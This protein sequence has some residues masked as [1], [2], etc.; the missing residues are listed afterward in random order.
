MIILDSEGEDFIKETHFDV[1]VPIHV[2]VF[3]G[4]TKIFAYPFAVDTDTSPFTVI[5]ILIILPDRR[6]S[7][8]DT[9]S[10]S[11]SYICLSLTTLFHIRN[12]DVALGVLKVVV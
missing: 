1:A 5:V 2:E 6:T 11:F 12:G 9:P 4:E 3:E 10:F 7:T 8:L